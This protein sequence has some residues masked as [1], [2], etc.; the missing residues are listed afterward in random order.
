MLTKLTVSG[1]KNLLNAQIYFGPFTCIAGA[2]GVGKSNVFDAIHFLKLLTTRELIDAAQSIR[3]EHGRS[4]NIRGLFY[5]SGEQQ[6]NRMRFEVE[7]I[8]PR[9]ALD[10][11]RQ[12][13]NATSTLLRYTL[14]LGYRGEESAFGPLEILY[15]ELDYIIKSKAREHLLF[16]HDDAS[17][18]EPIIVAKRKTGKPYLRTE[19]HETGRVVHIQQ[20]GGTGG[21]PQER[22]TEPLPRTVL[23]SLSAA[24]A[25]TAVVAR[26]E[27]S[28]WRLLQ[29]EPTA[30]R[31]S[32]ELRD[33][34]E[35]ATDGAHLPATLHR[36]VGNG[37]L[38]PSGN[39][40]A[41]RQRIANRL[42]ELVDEIRE[43]R[44]EK[45]E[46]RELLTLLARLRD[47]TE[48]S[49]RSLSD[50]TLRFLALAIIE[51]STE[52][53]GLF[54]LEEPENGIHPERVPAMLN[55]LK[56]IAVDP[57]EPDGPDN[58]LRQ[59]I[60]NTHSP[61]VVS[62]VPDDS[63]VI[64]ESF[65]DDGAPH[66]LRGTV[67]AVRFSALPDTWRVSEA[68]VHACPKGTLLKYLNPLARRDPEKKQAGRRN[69]V[70][71]REDIQ[72]LLAFP[73]DVSDAH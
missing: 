28:S 72:P 6:V 25:R 73:R 62:E 44:V 59:V 50:G 47:G 19:D 13:A 22:L 58:P 9:S 35:V 12:T 36:L 54:C 46:K 69:R 45:D 70:I 56:D 27:M 8:A 41:V 55:L 20:D 21:R 68:S 39:G 48:H 10:H 26:A 4:G 43:I 11:L 16:P 5:R 3:D 2:N 51:Q 15:E 24:E 14:E 66:G 29:L 57:R 1:F 33:P 38:G 61:L 53:G 49:A 17:W 64:A 7:M 63:L 30:L 71:D 32:D 18:L 65:R 60:V 31:R 37:K 52:G 67:A 40:D 34:S 23:S 42:S